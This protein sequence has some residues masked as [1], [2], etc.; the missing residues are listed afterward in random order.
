MTTYTFNRVEQNL[1]NHWNAIS[2][3][4]EEDDEA[5]FREQDMGVISNEIDLFVNQILPF[6]PTEGWAYWT[7]GVRIFCENRQ[8]MIDLANA[9]APFVTFIY[10]NTDD[11][12]ANPYYIS[13]ED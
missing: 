8:Q 7:D 5:F 2:E 13:F 10:G 3:T 12:H 11:D 6:M 1:I 9:I 4:W